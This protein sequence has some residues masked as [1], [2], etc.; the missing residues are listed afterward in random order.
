MTGTAW[1]VLW[2]VILLVSLLV[3]V[4]VLLRTYRSFRVLQ[5]EV[6]R[7]V[8]SFSSVKAVKQTRLTQSPPASNE[9][10]R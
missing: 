7:L 2:A 10:E 4:G 3:W 9:E 1:L 5:I 8:A 6:S